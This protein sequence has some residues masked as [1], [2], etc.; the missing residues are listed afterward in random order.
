MAINTVPTGL[1]GT[2]PVGPAIP[3]IPIP[4]SALASRFI[5]SA[6]FTQV[7]LDTAPYLMITGEGMLKIL[8]LDLLLYVVTPRR[9]YFELPG[10]RVK[11][12]ESIPPV[13]DS[14]VAMVFPF[15]FCSFAWFIMD[16]SIA[17]GARAFYG[18]CLIRRDPFS[19]AGF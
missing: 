15:F 13:Q 16:L 10:L 3:L 7:S 6:I 2:A 18:P 1:P 12:S 11:N 17:M 5:A 19:C 8:F 9:K 4:I 14:A